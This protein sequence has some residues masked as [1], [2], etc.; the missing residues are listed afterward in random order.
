MRTVR[1]LAWNIRQ[2]GGQRVAAIASAIQKTGAHVAIPTAIRSAATLNRADTIPR[3][4]PA[5]T[6]TGFLP[7][8][9]PV[10]LL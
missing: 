3:R 4:V 8:F 5:N 6:K 10:S 7:P 2:G 1:I 9:Q